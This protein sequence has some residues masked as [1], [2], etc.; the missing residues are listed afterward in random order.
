MKSSKALLKNFAFLILISLLF[1]CRRDSIVTVSG[2]LVGNCDQKGVAH[3]KLRMS[4]TK[5][6]SYF[7]SSKI[8]S[9]SNAGSGETDDNGNFIFNILHQSSNGDWLLID[10]NNGQIYRVI[11][12]AMS[13]SKLE[14]G[15]IFADSLA[16]RAKVNL[17]FKNRI[18]ASDTL[19]CK[20]YDKTDTLFLSG[21]KNLQLNFEKTSTYAGQIPYR[22]DEWP[23]QWG[24]GHNDFMK[25]DS[26]HLVK[27]KFS[28]CNFQP[29]SNNLELFK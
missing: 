14:F 8:K 17:T 24:F 18:D 22:E 13:N 10:E 12:Y 20:V 7:T 27:I 19:F 11:M 16:Y 9:N 2:R 28:T 25:K 29:Y 1:G 21:Q 26:V 3:H 6:K 23:F 5:S 15:E 4:Y